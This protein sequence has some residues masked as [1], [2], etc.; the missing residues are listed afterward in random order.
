M[1]KEGLERAKHDDCRVCSKDLGGVEIVESMAGAELF[2]WR[3]KS[4]LNVND[5]TVD[6]M[7]SCIFAQSQEYGKNSE[8]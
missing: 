2:L 1:A 8:S 5:G 4:G 7:S 6:D 3:K